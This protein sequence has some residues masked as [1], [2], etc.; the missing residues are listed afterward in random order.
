M[1][2]KH[3]TGYERDLLAASLRKRI[4][5][6]KIARQLGRAPSS[7][8]REVRRNSGDRI[9]SSFSAHTKAQHRSRGR[10]PR[11]MWDKQTVKAVKQQLK[12]DHAPELISGRL[13]IIPTPIFISHQT[14]Y[15]WIYAERK[16]GRTWHRYLPRRGKKYFRKRSGTT[17]NKARKSITERPPEVETRERVGDWEADTLEGKKGGRAIVPVLERSTRFTILCRVKNRSSATLNEAVRKRF[18]YQRGLPRKTLTVDRGNEFGDGTGLAKAFKA[19]VYFADPYS[20]WQ[21]GAVEQVNG[22]LR[23]YFPKGFDRV[24]ARDLQFAEDRLNHR[25]RKCLGFRTPYE[26][27]FDVM[28]A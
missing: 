1:S 3:F 2:H 6:R 27:L 11:K 28:P 17:R 14:I 16:Q 4:S 26:V 18:A 15:N 5:L 23:R 24:S 21:K 13:K 22:L 8:S 20:P 25:P 12:K 10:P 19:E 7:I 9:Y